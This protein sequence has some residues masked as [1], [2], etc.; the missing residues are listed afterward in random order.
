MDMDLLFAVAEI[1]RWS[2]AAMR[3]AERALAAAY[4][5]IDRVDE[6]LLR[7]E[8]GRSAGRTR[9]KVIVQS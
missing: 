9:R 1:E 4:D 8:A 2:L 5:Q 7:L 6:L 3:R